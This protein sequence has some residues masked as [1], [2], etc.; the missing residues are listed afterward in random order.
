MSTEPDNGCDH[1][2]VFVCACCGEQFCH[3]CGAKTPPREETT[4]AYRLCNKCHDDGAKLFDDKPSA[5]WDA[6]DAVKRGRKP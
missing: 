3:A 6:W 1:R 4:T 2:S 5:A